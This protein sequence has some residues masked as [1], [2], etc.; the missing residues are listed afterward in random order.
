ME[1]LALIPNLDNH[2][3]NAHVK[4]VLGREM[5]NADLTYVETP[6]HDKRNCCR[7]KVLVP[8]VR[9]SEA[10]SEHFLGHVD[11]VDEGCLMQALDSAPPVDMASLPPAQ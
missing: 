1:D 5:G 9:P 11:A 2:N 8:I 4:L 7:S 10:L 3:Q 6:M